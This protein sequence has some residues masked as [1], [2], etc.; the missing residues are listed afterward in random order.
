MT[1]STVLIG[2]V[3]LVGHVEGLMNPVTGHTV[4]KFLSFKVWLMTLHTVRDISMFVMM[5]DCTVKPAMGTGIVFYLVDLGRMT[6]VADGN[7][8]FTEN[9]MQGLM[10]VL[11]TTEARLLYFKVGLSFMAHGTLGNNLSL[12]RGRGMAADMT[13]KTGDRRF[14]ACSIVL[15]L[16]DDGR[17][18]FY[19]V[20]DLQH[21]IRSQGAS[22]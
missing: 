5:A 21:R 15:V 7:I 22:C 4:G 8:I 3:F 9:D 17:M 12:F 6:G 10:W 1:G 18:A 19:A 20:A 11:M 13:I 2:D 16:M 14:V